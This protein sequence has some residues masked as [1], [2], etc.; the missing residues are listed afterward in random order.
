[1]EAIARSIRDKLL[2]L[3]DDTQVVTGHGPETS[4]GAERRAN[5]FIADILGR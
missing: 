3:P 2:A 4:I 1:M 5:P